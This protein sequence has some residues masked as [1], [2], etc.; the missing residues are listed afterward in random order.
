MNFALGYPLTD[1][2]DRDSFVDVV[3]DYREH[4]HEVYFP[5]IDSP[6]GRSAL[7]TRRG[8]TD[9]TAQHRLE[10]DLL[11][12]R[13]MGVKLD[14]L[15]NANCYGD[16]AISTQ[17]ENQVGSLL[18][19]LDQHVGGVDVVTTTSP[20]IARC[21]KK[22]FPHVETRASVNMR[23]GTASAMSL[24]SELFDSFYVQRD[25]QRN[26]AAIRKLRA[27]A[28]RAGR[29]L[30]VLANS[31]CFHVCPGQT[32]HDN[33]VAHEAGVAETQNVSDWNPILCWRTLKDQS[34]WPHVLQSTWIRPEDLHHFEGLADVVKLATRMHARP[35][36]VLDAY[37]SGRHRGNLLDLFE[38]AFSPAF[39]P[40]AIDNDRFPDDWFEKTSTC[41]HDCEACGYCA[42]VL[43]R[44]LIQV[45]DAAPD[46][47]ADLD[48]ENAAGLVPLTIAHT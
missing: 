43:N 21:I 40:H 19:H 26:L 22:H 36:M 9:W 48:S 20:F 32:F 46:V 42:G 34:R 1:P 11:A 7:A 13:E 44:V 27:W 33:L 4:V 35:R 30:C 18:D 10:D 31:G 3:R 41:D 14:L 45:D 47:N 8:C 28:D 15:F 39:A 16:K 38:P 6:S 2:D 23:I 12:L 5:W 29:K 37:T 17:L 24:V 25:V